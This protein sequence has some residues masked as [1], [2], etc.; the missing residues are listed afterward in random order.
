[1]TEA[2]NQ[3]QDIQ[4]L[5]LQLKFSSFQWCLKTNTKEISWNSANTDLLVEVFVLA[6]TTET[7]TCCFL[8]QFGQKSNTDHE[9][10]LNLQENS[11]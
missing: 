3:Y 6:F 5:G 10:F 1:M 8:C 7:G 11:V 9:I 4:F 2:G